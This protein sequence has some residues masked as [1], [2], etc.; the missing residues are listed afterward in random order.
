M[1]IHIEICD[2][3]E[4]PSHGLPVLTYSIIGENSVRHICGACQ[5]KP[6][7]RVEPSTKARALADVIALAL[8]GAA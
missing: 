8:K 5:Q 7:R 1:I 3:C 2:H 6:F 4:K